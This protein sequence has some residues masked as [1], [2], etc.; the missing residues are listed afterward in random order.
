MVNA[1]VTAW[2]G[3]P[4]ANLQVRGGCFSGVGVVCN[5]TALAITSQAALTRFKARLQPDEAQRA[6]LLDQLRG[7]LDDEERDD[8]R[9]ALERRPVVA[10]GSA[11]GR[12]L[13]PAVNR[14]NGVHRLVIPGVTQ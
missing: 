7:I 2:E 5:A 11:A 8:F 9:A 14:D 10:L 4:R 1:W 12:F 13:A 3:S 6:E